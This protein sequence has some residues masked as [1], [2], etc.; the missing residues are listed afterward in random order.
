MKPINTANG[1]ILAAAGLTNA[2]DVDEFSIMLSIYYQRVA[3]ETFA[4]RPFPFATTAQP[5][6]ARASSFVQQ[7]SL[8]K[9]L[10]FDDR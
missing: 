1:M 6:L 9:N 8:K 4:A 2:E 3:C 10:Q 5:Q 7:R